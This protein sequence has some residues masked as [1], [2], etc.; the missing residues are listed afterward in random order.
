MAGHRIVVADDDLDTLELMG[1][2]LTQ[3]GF[4]PILCSEAEDA[5][6]IVRR[7]QPD[8][9]ILGL[10]MGS[11]ETGWQ[12]LNLLRGDP[13]TT[14]IPALMYS[15]HSDFLRVRAGVLRRQRCATLEKPFALPDLLATIAEALA[16]RG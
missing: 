6:V 10:Q 7:T 14:H 9:V 16:L 2:L 13:T 12:I 3:E 15:A 4:Q 5:Y 8:L 11:P 1:D